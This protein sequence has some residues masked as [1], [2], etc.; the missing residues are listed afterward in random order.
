ME[1]WHVFYFYFNKNDYACFGN[2]KGQGEGK[3]F[4]VH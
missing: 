2:N 4:N 1:R 3:H